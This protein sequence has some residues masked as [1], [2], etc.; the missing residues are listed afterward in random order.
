VSTDRAQAAGLL[1]VQTQ[2]PIFRLGIFGYN[3][4]A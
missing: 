3:T 4:F 2:D 1:P